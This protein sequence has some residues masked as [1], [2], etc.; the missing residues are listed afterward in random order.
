[1]FD[2]WYSIIHFSN[3]EYA[4]SFGNFSNVEDA[5]VVVEKLIESRV[6]GDTYEIV[7]NWG[8]ADV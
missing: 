1:M 8:I 6:G 2:I 3:G 7:V 5:I 4:N